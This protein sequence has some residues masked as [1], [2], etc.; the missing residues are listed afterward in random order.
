[1]YLVGFEINERGIPRQ[2]YDIVN[3]AGEKIGHV[4]SGTMGPSVDK[5]IGMGYVDL[6]FSKVDTNINIQ[7]RKKAVPATVVKTPFYK[8]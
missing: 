2:G 4:T 6:A 1:M 5:G 8:K 7:I 3:D